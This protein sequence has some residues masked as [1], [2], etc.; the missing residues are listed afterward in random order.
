MPTT[1]DEPTEPRQ[2]LDLDAWRAMTPAQRELMAR[3]DAE[4]ERRARRPR[5]A[6]VAGVALTLANLATAAQLG[7]ALFDEADKFGHQVRTGG[8]DGIIALLFMAPLWIWAGGACLLVAS[9]AVTCAV[10]AIH[11]VRAQRA[12][13]PQAASA[14]RFVFAL[15]LGVRLCVLLSMGSL[16]WRLAPALIDGAGLLASLI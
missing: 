16:D 12:G 11:G 7:A 14:W 2:E 15:D 1:T 10:V 4:E 8:G 5:R 9:W 3:A 6:L 13:A